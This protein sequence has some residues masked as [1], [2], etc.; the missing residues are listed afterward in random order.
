MLLANSVLASDPCLFDTSSV[1]VD[2][3]NIRG[4]PVVVTGYYGSSRENI[5]PLLPPGEIDGVLDIG[6]GYGNAAVTIKER[7]GAKNVGVIDLVASENNANR[8]LDFASVGDLND[9][10]TIQ[11]VGEAHGPFDVVLCLD[12]LEHLIDPWRLVGSLDKILSP[13]GVIIASIPNVAHLSVSLKLF[14]FGQWRLYDQGILDRTHLR[15]FT[16]QT[17]IELMETGSLK[18]DHCSYTVSRNAYFKRLNWMQHLIGS[19]YFAFQFLL[20]A[21]APDARERIS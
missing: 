8:N 15:F 13:K 7:R 3:G 2:A 4:S 12:V 14:L 21:G 18:V 5:L 6:G 11:K 16:K 10:S 19:R 1:R 9:V 20:R 17:A